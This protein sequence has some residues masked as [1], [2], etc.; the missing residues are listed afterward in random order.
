TPGLPAQ[1]EIFDPSDPQPLATFNV[2]Q[3]SKPV[4]L[5]LPFSG[6]CNMNTGDS[7][8]PNCHDP[9]TASAPVRTIVADAAPPPQ[10]TYPPTRRAD[11]CDNLDGFVS[12]N[13]SPLL[14]YFGSVCNKRVVVGCCPNEGGW[15]IFSATICCVKNHKGRFCQELSPGDV[16]I[17]GAATPITVDLGETVTFTVHNNG[18]TGDTDVAYTTDAD[19]SLG[20]SLNGAGFNGATIQHYDAD[21]L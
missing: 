21:K 3:L 5:Q 12:S 15:L 14:S 8:V 18:C 13:T 7:L 9:S 16:A 1:G 2:S 19:V 10:P 17:L 4:V 11:S 6:V 20:G